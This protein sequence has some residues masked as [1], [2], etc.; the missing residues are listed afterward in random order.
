[1]SVEKGR[2]ITE[3]IKKWRKIPTEALPVA[4]KKEK[5]EESSS[6]WYLHQSHAL[7]RAVASSCP[8]VVGVFANNSPEWVEEIVRSVGID[9]V[10]LSGTESHADYS[11]VSVPVWKALH[12]ANSPDAGNDLEKKIESTNGHYSA[13]LLDTQDANALGGT[14]KAF[15][16]S[17]ARSLTEKNHIFFLAGGLSPDNVTGAVTSSKPFGVDVSSGV[18]SSPGVKDLHKIKQFILNAKQ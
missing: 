9:I 12:V 2:S 13:L 11:C 14:G 18:E 3:A 1:M 15:D 7:R 17:I 16:W 8:L 6:E 10:Q 5:E 4:T